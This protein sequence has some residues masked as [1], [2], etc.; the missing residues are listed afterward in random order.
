MAPVRRTVQV[1]PQ[2]VS[3]ASEGKHLHRSRRAPGA[4]STFEVHVLKVDSRVWDVAMGLA[5]GDA[6]RLQVVSSEEVIVLNHP[7]K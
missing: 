5:D 7:R 1:H 2:T 6:R 3:E 4:R